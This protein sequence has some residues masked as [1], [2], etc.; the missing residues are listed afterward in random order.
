MPVDVNLTDATASV[1]NAG[2]SMVG[3]V[4]VMLGLALVISF[5]RKRA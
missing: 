2:T 3:V 1:T 5:L 4:I